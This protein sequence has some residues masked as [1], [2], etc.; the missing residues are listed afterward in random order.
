MRVAWRSGKFPSMMKSAKCCCR[1]H[2]IIRCEKC[3]VAGKEHARWMCAVYH[4]RGTP[5]SCLPQVQMP[6]INVCS[7]LPITSS[8]FFFVRY[9]APR[10]NCI[11]QYHNYNTRAFLTEKLPFSLAYISA[12]VAYGSIAALALHRL[13][14]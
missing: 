10:P 9:G 8:K 6:H 3:R 12:L 14:D 1:C 11:S 5:C 2:I 4:L 13:Q 7:H